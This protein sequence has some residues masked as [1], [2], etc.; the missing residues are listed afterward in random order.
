MPPGRVARLVL[1]SATDP[2]TSALMTAIP[3]TIAAHDVT[4]R[5][6]RREP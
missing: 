4:A 1:P 3:V 2:L 6:C 5:A